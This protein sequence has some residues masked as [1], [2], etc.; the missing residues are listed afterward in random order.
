LFGLIVAGR[1]CESHELD[2]NLFSEIHVVQ[3]IYALLKK[4]AQTT[5][6]R[7]GESTSQLSAQLSASEFHYQLTIRMLQA[8]SYQKEIGG[9]E[10]PSEVLLNSEE[11][12]LGRLR[13]GASKKVR[14]TPVEDLVDKG[15]WIEHVSV[16]AYRMCHAWHHMLRLRLSS[17]TFAGTYSTH[18]PLLRTKWSE[19]CQR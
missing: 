1:I 15:K 18:T 2:I 7:K 8:I 11:K 19:C 9:G 12:R 5:A 14:Y 6:A 13:K 17:N 4:R 16:I 10:Q 3:K